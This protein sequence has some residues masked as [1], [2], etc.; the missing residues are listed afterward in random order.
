MRPPLSVCIPAH[1]EETFIGALLEAIRPQ[2]ASHDEVVVAA[3]GCTDGTEAIVRAIAVHDARVTLVPAPQSKNAAWN[4]LVRTARHG[5]LVFLDADVRPASDLVE[6]LS[7]PLAADPHLVAT[8]GIDLPWHEKGPAPLHW[9]IDRTF[10]ARQRHPY[11]QGRCYAVR[12]SE[13]ALLARDQ[14]WSGAD[15]LPELPGSIVGEDVFL[16]AVLPRD[17]FALVRDTFVRYHL[18]TLEDV[19]I[20]LARQHVAWH[21][22]S[23]EYPELHAQA[24]PPVALSSRLAS[25][26]RR[27]VRG[28]LPAFTEHALQLAT[29]AAVER[30]LARRIRHH[31]DRMLADLN[32]G[33]GGAVLST[34]GRLRSKRSRGSGGAFDQ[35]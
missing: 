29:R 35:G 27:L 26:V 8:S 13:L 5:L 7:A 6:K 14:G 19:A 10:P 9:L 25:A 22:L 11:L 12:R 33:R 4:T 1:N 21:Q 28:P 23:V 18:D 24:L 31:R 30:L 15:G 34:S 17:R 20:S 32:A 3:S 16:M 2:L